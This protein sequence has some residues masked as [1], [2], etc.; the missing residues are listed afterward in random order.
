[1]SH[2]ALLDLCFLTDTTLQLDD[3]VLC[4]IY[5][6]NSTHEKSAGEIIGSGSS[7]EQHSVE[8]PISSPSSH[9]DDVLDSLPEL[10][11]SYLNL[12]RMDSL[13]AL[14]HDDKI[15]LQKL[16]SGNFDWATLA[17]LSTL[18]EV[19]AES[20]Q[21]GLKL[22]GFVN[23]GFNMSVG[24][25]GGSVRKQFKGSL[26]NGFDEEVQSEI[27]MCPNPGLNEFG[28]GFV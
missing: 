22:R 24:G 27:K 7:V 14:L 21:Q 25:A 17:G 28:S 8:S 9:L 13:K 20:W 11:P 3:W 4:R 16:G 12:R 5:K 23:G 15:N 10:E 26:G 18:P 6:K 1:M 2:T 19:V